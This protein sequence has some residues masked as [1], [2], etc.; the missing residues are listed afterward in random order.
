M[1]VVQEVVDS[2]E[3]FDAILAEVGAAHLCV[4]YTDP[5]TEFLPNVQAS[6]ESNFDG[7]HSPDGD[8]WPALAASTIARKGHDIP[9]VEFMR[10]KPSILELSHPDHVG[11][12][13]HRGFLF[14]TS[15]EYAGFHQFGTG[16]IPQRE[17]VGMPSALVDELVDVV[18]DHEVES[19]KL[20]V[21]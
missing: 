20:K 17:F 12:V 18:A 14:G 19:L 11:G 7:R 6:H 2:F 15:V 1:T 9:L 8:P 10:L 16:K 4:D 3:G 21:G 5:L 13:S